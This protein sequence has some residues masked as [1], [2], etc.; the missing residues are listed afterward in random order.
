MGKKKSTNK[1]ASRE[2]SKTEIKA[3]ELHTDAVERLAGADENAP[4]FDEK[5]LKKYHRGFL[6]NIPMWI[7][8]L[9]VKFWFNGAVCYFFIMGLG[10]YIDSTTDLLIVLALAMG[11]FNSLIV[12]NVLLFLDDGT[13][14]YSR[15]IFLPQPKFEKPVHK[16]LWAVGSLFLDIIYAALVVFIV[17]LIYFGVNKA[18]DSSFVVEPITFGLM[19]LA[20]DLMFIGI[21]NLGAAIVKDAVEK[22]K[23]G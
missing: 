7:K 11:A 2:P 6:D 21:K 1:N 23:V 17:Y 3:Y 9:F 19:Y 15:W 10:L 8:A 22:N 5:E 20:V 14:G 16:A 4:E 18:T 12:N 13:G